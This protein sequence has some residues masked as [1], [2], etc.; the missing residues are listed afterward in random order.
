[1]CLAKAFINNSSKQPIL[2]DIARMRVHKDRVKLETLLG[3]EKVVTGNV[4]EVDFAA[5]RIL[6]DEHPEPDGFS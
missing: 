6:L 3:E 5:S 4:V 2:E 1:M